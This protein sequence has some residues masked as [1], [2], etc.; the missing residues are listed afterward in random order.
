[1][2][3]AGSKSGFSLLEVLATLALMALSLALVVPSF[4]TAIKRIDQRSA[5]SR[6]QLQLAAEHF[7]AVNEGISY[8]VEAIEGATRVVNPN[9][10]VGNTDRL[11]SITLQPSP[12]WTI[13][14]EGNLIISAAEGCS[15]GPLI[16]R[17]D[18]G[19]T[20]R[21]SVDTECAVV[22]ADTR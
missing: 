12:G 2:S 21:L 3:V 4:S 19:E 5:V 13:K 11:I 18:D 1:M 16:L 10:P 6:V 8:R 17:N 14:A 22:R 20:V 9:G 7:R 15:G